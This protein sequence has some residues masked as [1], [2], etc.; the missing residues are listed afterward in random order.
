MGNVAQ[1]SN[2]QGSFQVSFTPSTSQKGSVP[3]LTGQAT[4][5][6]YDRF[7]GVQV[8]ATADPATTETTQDP[9]YTSANATVQ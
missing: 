7:A 3:A 5:S 8:S 1:N 9:G 2:V 6:G 4:F